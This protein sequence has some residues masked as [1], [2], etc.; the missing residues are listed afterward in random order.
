MKIQSNRLL[1]IC[2]PALCLCL[3]VATDTVAE[4]GESGGISFSVG[5]LL[6]GDAYHLPSHHLP[7]GDGAS[8]A[9]LRRGY[10]TMDGSQ[11]PSWFGR[12]RFEANQ[13]GEFETYDFEADVK[14]LY[15]GYRF[16]DHQI[17]A[18]LQP[19]LTFDFVESS[20]GKRY[21]MR[22]PTD[23]QGLPSRDAG[24][25]LKGRL[26]DQFSY[27][28]MI[29]A[30]ADFGA[31]SGDGAAT[32]LALNWQFSEHWALDF[33]YDRERRPGE[34]DTTTAQLFAAYEGDHHRFGAQYVYRDRESQSPGE[35]AS[36]YAI[37]ALE[38]G[39]SV[40]GRVDRILEP[41][42]KGDN[43]SY[44]PFDPSAKATMF[45]A[46]YEYRVSDH[47]LLTPNTIVIKYDED[48]LSQR[49]NTDIF[50]RVTL[51]LDFE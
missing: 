9:V 51:F 37:W 29:G 45:V 22:T 25:A 23:L 30:G 14:D 10:L 50:F 38:D 32:M 18:G 15:L 12:L 6:F 13:S 26:S 20:W 47:L 42:L 17:I 27:R 11:G 8:G 31:E 34:T 46:A 28:A 33:Y 3:G 2:C 39:K 21:L 41:S 36:V 44:I 7:S 4:S 24:I 16:A 40:I 19:T 1:L 35:L 5:G 48:E 49:P 43:I